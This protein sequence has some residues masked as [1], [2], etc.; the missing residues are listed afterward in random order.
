MEN[1]TTN[2]AV[3]D[4]GDHRDGDDDISNG[5]AGKE[6]VRRAVEVPVLDDVVG[7][8]PV[9]DEAPD[10]DNEVKDGETQ[11]GVV[12]R[13]EALSVVAALVVAIVTVGHLGATT[14]LWIWMLFLAKART[15]GAQPPSAANHN[16][17]CAS[18][19]F[20]FNSHAAEAIRPDRRVGA[21][22]SACGAEEEAPPLPSFLA[23]V[24]SYVRRS[25]PVSSLTHS[26]RP[27]GLSLS[28]GSAT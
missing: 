24:R 11:V 19:Q 5:Q 16:A 22:A 12:V 15:I 7:E 23:P 1:V 27:R 3:D 13:V 28:I 2:L 9:A 26:H 10:D 17:L 20:S 21:A 25:L 6:K 14:T 8:E 4:E 18:A